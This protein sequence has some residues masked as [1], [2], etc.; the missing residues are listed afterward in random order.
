[1]IMRPAW[2]SRTTPRQRTLAVSATFLLVAGVGLGVMALVIAALDKVGAP[3]AV[4]ASPWYL[5]TAG[6]LAWSMH[7]PRPGVVTEDGADSWL[8]F[9][10]RATMVGVGAARPR[11]LRAIAAVAFGAPVAWGLIVVGALVLLGIG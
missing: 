4:T 5:P 10:I 8:I 1:M 6:A 2:R 11:P 7:R 3:G 9:S